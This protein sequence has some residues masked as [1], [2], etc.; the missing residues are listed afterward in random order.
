M[1]LHIMVEDELVAELD[2]RVGRGRRSAYVA[3]LIRNALA[4]ERRWDDLESGFG[5]IGDTGHEWDEDPG[6]WVRSQRRAD[7][8]R[9]G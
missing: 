4:D 6:A 1:R 7:E 3:Q 5:S 2:E 8:H 9:V